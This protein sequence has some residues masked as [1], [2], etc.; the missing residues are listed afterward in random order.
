MMIEPICI[1]FLSGPRKAEGFQK[2]QANEL[3]GVPRTRQR[4]HVQPAHG[5]AAAMALP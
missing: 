1:R 3:M 5:L 2:P 4:R